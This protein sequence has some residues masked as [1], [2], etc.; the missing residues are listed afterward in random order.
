MD[1]DANA[2]FSVRLPYGVPYNDVHWEYVQRYYSKYDDFLLVMYKALEGANIEI[3]IKNAALNEVDDV[4]KTM[5]RLAHDMSD[6]MKTYHSSEGDTNVHMDQDVQLV[7][8]WETRI[9]LYRVA[10]ESMR[11][12][13]TY[14]KE[15]EAMFVF[16]DRIGR[17]MERSD[18]GIIVLLQEMDPKVEARQEW[19]D[20][21]YAAVNGDRATLRYIGARV[22]VLDQQLSM[23][24]RTYDEEEDVR[25]AYV[26]MTNNN[27]NNNS[28]K[29]KI[30]DALTVYHYTTEEIVEEFDIETNSQALESL[31][32][33]LASTEPTLLYHNNQLVPASG[34]LP[35]TSL[36]QLDIDDVTRA[37]MEMHRA[38]PRDLRESEYITDSQRLIALIS[39]AIDM[40]K[41]LRANISH[42][43][44]TA[45]TML[46]ISV[47]AGFRVA[48]GNC[49]VHRVTLEG[50]PVEVLVATREVKKGAQ[51]YRDYSDGEL[52]K[53]WEAYH[54]TSPVVGRMPR[55]QKLRQYVGGL[56][57]Q[58]LDALGQRR[59]E[60]ATDLA[61]RIKILS[62]LI[63]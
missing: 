2:L 31:H 29:V 46:D 36:K 34:G 28:V 14:F 19:V 47:F 6:F 53:I 51:L 35:V 27:N 30:E 63:A 4:I 8:L 60:E 61:I 23:R 9:D 52:Y 57:M 5:T 12:A 43:I 10:R 50:R 16:S 39:S 25:A 3:T 17:F 59:T 18:P 45:T 49:T 1:V 41:F 11:S 48:I 26:A 7:E 21:Y 15:C 42:V 33:V 13:L 58:R 20:K 54:D 32:K 56:Q 22:S 37:R 38:A 40:E 55:S 44:S 62:G 24:M